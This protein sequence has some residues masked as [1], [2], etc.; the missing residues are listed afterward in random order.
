[1]ANS[2]PANNSRWGCHYSVDTEQ[3]NFAGA[4]KT[5]ETAR[6]IGKPGF[7][8]V[9]FNI[10]SKKRNDGSTV[11]HFGGDPE[12]DN[13]IPIMD[14]W[15]YIV[16]FYQPKDAILNGEWAFPKAVEVK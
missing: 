8:I 9:A 11:L 5:Q 12:A 6:A 1:M 15:L 13:F 3:A 7:R 14:G 16:R 10:T 2:V 4:P